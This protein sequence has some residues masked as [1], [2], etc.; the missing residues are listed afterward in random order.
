MAYYPIFVPYSHSSGCDYQMICNTSVNGTTLCQC[1][2]DPADGM[3]L[4]ILGV[5]TVAMIIGVLLLAKHG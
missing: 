4:L 5:I 2:P 3:I 1:I